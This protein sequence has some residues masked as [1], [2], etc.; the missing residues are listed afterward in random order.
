MTAARELL[1]CL[2]EIGATVKPEGHD[3]LI[4]RAGAQPIPGK[5]VQQ[6][7]E[8]KV[9]ILALVARP[10]ETKDREK[11]ADTA[12]ARHCGDRFAARIVHWFAGDRGWDEAEMVAFGELILDW[13]RRHAARLDSHRCAGC[14]EQLPD[15]TGIIIDRDGARVHFDAVRRDSCI[16]AFGSQWRKEAVAG[17]RALGIDAPP[18]FTLL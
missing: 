18:G 16:I 5:L 1:D 7:R 12:E 15:G 8:A 13:Y 3:R 9:E 6:L 4:L 10:P 17:L 11:M 2:A 14:G